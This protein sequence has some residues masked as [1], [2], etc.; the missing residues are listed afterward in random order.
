[1]RNAGWFGTRL[2]RLVLLLLLAG[3]L[4]P[5][6]PA[7]AGDPM[8]L[9]KIVHGQCVPHEKAERDPSPCAEVDLANGE[10]KGYALLK[11]RKGIAQ[12]LLI[13]T[14][15]VTGIEDPALLYPDAPNY[16]DDAWRER[17]FVEERLESPVPRD[18]MTLAINSAL[19]RSQDQLHIHI[20]CIRPDVR[21]ILKANLDKI[22]G[23]WTPFPVP[24]AG[25]HYRS[26]RISDISLANVNPFRLLADKDPQAADEMGHHTLVVVGATFPDSGD[27]FILLDGKTDPAHGNLGWGEE[28]QDHDCK[29]MGK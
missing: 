23:V 3:V 10:S 22:E 24:L 17:Y 8:V 26:I 27:G 1:M 12:F 4:A 7:R 11:D 2:I 9:W 18:A 20:D 13:P 6:I 16:F 5:A 19:G 15:R 14:A 21:A 29:V 28:L 25:H